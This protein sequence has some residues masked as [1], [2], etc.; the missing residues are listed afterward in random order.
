MFKIV[1]HIGL[2][3]VHLDL[4]AKRMVVLFLK[5]YPTCKQNL[6]Q[7]FCDQNLPYLLTKFSKFTKMNQIPIPILV[8]SNLFTGLPGMRHL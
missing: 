1:V 8:K 4:Y 3:I 5:I 6:P 2:E 7:K